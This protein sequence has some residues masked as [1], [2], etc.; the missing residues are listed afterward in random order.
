MRSGLWL[1]TLAVLVNGVVCHALPVLSRPDLLFSVTID[2]SFRAQPFARA[3]LRRYRWAVWIGTAAAL[4]LLRV[5][6]MNNAVIVVLMQSLVLG[7]AWAWAHGRIKP[8]AL[9]LPATRVASLARR[10]DRLPGGALLAA[11][12]FLIV[13]AAAILLATHWDRIP[14]RFPT[15]WTTDGTPNG[16]RQRT[17]TGVYGP[18]A[19]GTVMISFA[20]VQAFALLRRTRQIALD[21]VAA[22]SEQKFKHVTALYA[23]ASSYLMALLF[24][25]F[26]VRPILGTGEKLGPA[27]WVVPFGIVAMSTAAMVWM[28]RVGQAGQR[29]LSPS[30]RRGARGD[31]TPDDAWKAGMIYFNPADPAWL[32]EKRMGIGWTF[33]F[34]H[35]LTWVMLA[36]LVALPFV[37]RLLR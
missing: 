33:N 4:G 37:L 13:A 21:G 7:A 8:H 20:L 31:A 28:M 19:M 9:T 12:P 32:V 26:A 36:A 18:L 3:V 16:W 6:T 10:D 30:Q 15:H 17:V 1:M 11:G 29:G 25:G 23:I 24:G 27:I 34:G 35:K 5:G 22:A 14:A 2:E